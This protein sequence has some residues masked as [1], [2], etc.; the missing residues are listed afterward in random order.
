MK[1]NQGFQAQTGG[2]ELVPEN[3]LIFGDNDASHGRPFV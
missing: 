1:L 3:C 2:I